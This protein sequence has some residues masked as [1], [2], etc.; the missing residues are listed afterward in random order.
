MLSLL[1]HELIA[2]IMRVPFAVMSLAATGV[3]FTPP[4][5]DFI[6]DASA[7]RALDQMLT[8]AIS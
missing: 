1:T 7:R 3:K 2:I 5:S 6:T 8:R 4:D